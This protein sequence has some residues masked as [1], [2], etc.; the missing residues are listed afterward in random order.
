MHH[1]VDVIE[2]IVVPK[3]RDFES[4]RHEPSVTRFIMGNV[5]SMLPAIKLDDESLR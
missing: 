3:P 2:H 4:L 1:T 5:T